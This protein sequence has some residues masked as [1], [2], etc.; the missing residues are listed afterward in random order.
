MPFPAS[1]IEQRLAAARKDRRLAH[2]YLLTGDNLDELQALFQRLSA[3]LL[4]S[5][6]PAHADLHV[7]QPESKSRRLTVEQV[8]NL[9]QQLQL[10]ARDSDLKVAGII[11]A[12]RM[13]I[14]SAEAANAFLKTLEEPPAHTVIFL[15]TDRPEQL[16][17]TIR[18]RCLVLTLESKGDRHAATPADT[19]WLEEWWKLQGT[20]GDRAYR[21]ASLLAAHWKKLREGVER[22][23]KDRDD[24]DSKSAL[25]ESEFL[26]ARDN[27]LRA[28]IHHSWAEAGKKLE[29]SEAALLVEG[30]EELRYALSRNI[31]QNTALERNFLMIEGLI[32]QNN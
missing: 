3:L 32:Y 28:L 16:L 18:S 24:D 20:P 14:G 4:Q 17:P 2:A 25:Q 9:E 30:L 19:A 15:L 10:K 8:R 26:L 5:S 31:D 27:S 1:W 13:C 12:D 6:N 7:I 29:Q 23:F 11:A 22:R 21:R